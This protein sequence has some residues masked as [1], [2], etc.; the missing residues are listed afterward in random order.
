MSNILRFD[1]VDPAEN[2][3]VGGKAVGLARLVSAG[4]PVPKGFVI[5][6]S[7]YEEFLIGNDLWSRIATL[8]TGL[9]YSDSKNLEELSAQ[10]RQLITSSP[11]ASEVKDQISSAYAGLGQEPYVAVRSSGTAED[12]AEASFAGLHDTYLNIK[13]ADATIDAVLRCWASMWSGRALAY[14]HASDVSNETARI[15]VVVQEMVESDVAGVMFTANPISARTDEIVVNASWG[16][17]EGLVSGIVV[18]DE[19][20]L[21]ARSLEIKRRKLGGKEVRVVRNPV[22]QIGTV[23]EP[24]SQEHQAVFSLSD[25]QVCKLAELGLRV[26]AYH[27]GLPQDIE[28][29]IAGGKMHLLQSRPV[30]GIE[31]TWDEDVDAWQKVPEKDDTIWTGGWAAEFWS[32]PITPL[33]YSVRAR[34]MWSRNSRIYKLLGFNDLM[35]FRWTKYRRGT[36]FYN[37]EIDSRLYTYL[38]PKSLRGGALSYHPATMREAI[39][40]EPMQ[41]SRFFKAMARLY[42]LNPSL[43][44]FRWERTLRKFMEDKVDHA[45]FPTP[46]ALRTW[47]DSQVRKHA[48]EVV[49]TA[50]KFLEYTALGAYVHAKPIIGILALMLKK[51]CKAA[52]AFTLQDIISGLPTASRLTEESRELWQLAQDIKRS[53]QL[54]ALFAAH[55]GK[56]F[57]DEAQKIDEGRSFL[58]KYRKFVVRHGHGGHSDRDIYFSRRVEDPSL[59]YASF[60]VLLKA[61]DTT[62]PE[63]HDAKLVRKREETTALVMASVR[64]QRFG[65]AKATALKAVHDW[66]LKFLLLRDDWRHSVNR[67]TLA[68]KF[69][70]KELGLRAFERGQLPSERS[71]YFISEQ[72]LYDVLDQRAPMQLIGAKVEA[73]QRVF[74]RFVAR[75]EAPP[76]FLSG[77]VPIDLDDVEASPA[78]D[79]LTGTSI[80]RGFAKGRARVIPDLKNIGNIMPG[81][82]LICNSTD[83]AWSPVFP[84]IAGLV[85]ETGGMLSHG[86]CLSREYGLAAVQLRNAMQ[87]IPDGI[88]LEVSGE[89]GFVRLLDENRQ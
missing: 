40:T 50:D 80:S 73:R 38:L 24:V 44:A 22:T 25:A 37:T 29:A 74:D 89:N 49:N 8:L 36:A 51:W 33:F 62:S 77:S 7:V 32:G 71:F 53:S 48:L 81:D 76:S 31:L 15:A 66:V 19:F 79:I 14:R 86:A 46:D 9:N 45:N 64:R 78:G 17:G 39:A 20:I 28:W 10:I 35:T 75:D 56:A 65:R 58:G 13:G 67:V 27:G 52:D 12:T 60:Q 47:S 82:I 72:E 88:M 5:T 11:I 54:S 57:F 42:L 55:E 16:L 43:G 30:T 2:N 84:I 1:E 83:P 6:T 4:L 63:E 18:P 69:A 21:S 87:R 68:K 3:R 59:D 41:V 26:A 85:L 61:V 70:F 23:T 34:E